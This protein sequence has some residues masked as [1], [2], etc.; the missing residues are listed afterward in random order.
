VAGSLHKHS[1]RQRI[2]LRGCFDERIPF[3]D[4]LLGGVLSGSDCLWTDI[5][6][7]VE[8]RECLV[9]G[10]VTVQSPFVSPML[11]K[12][13][14]LRAS[15]RRYAVAVG[16]AV[17]ALLMIFFREGPAAE[18]NIRLLL[19]AA[20]MLSSWYGGL[21]PGILT[22]LIAT[23]AV[24]YSYSPSGDYL[25][26]D[27]SHSVRLIEFVI[28]ALLITFLNDRRRKAQQRAEIAQQEAETANRT[29]DEFLGTISH[30]LRTPL[31]AVLGWTQVLLNEPK[32]RTLSV[33]GLNAIDRSARK[34][35]RL[36]DD[37]L[38]VSRMNAGQL[39]LDID[40]IDLA[41][42]IEAAIDVVSPAADAKG[43]KL[44]THI[45]GIAR[46]VAGDERRLQQVVWNLLSN[47]VKFTPEGGAI[48]IRLDYLDSH[49]RIVVKDTGQG[50]TPELLPHVFER[51]RQGDKSG[52][53]GNAGLGLG[54]AIARQLV[55]LHG[56][57]IEAKSNGHG[58]GAEFIIQIPFVAPTQAT[59]L[60]EEQIETTSVAGELSRHSFTFHLNR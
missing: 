43:L 41:S 47:A 18:L 4:T 37:L 1:V 24:T 60:K 17:A 48:E 42:V 46:L 40:S 27:L 53:A 7:R 50:I 56:G 20:V 29:K 44:R 52:P 21:G 32:D 12:K 2:H 16:C 38:D 58:Q 45:Q 59:R 30:E 10:L 6:C 15:W 28:V 19:L 39:H 8:R 57:T 3:D 9:E 11:I 54:L 36:I 33:R 31:T 55:E 14:D 13:E 34:Q 22:T 5:D 26:I 25:A 51:F 23:L 35:S 49:S